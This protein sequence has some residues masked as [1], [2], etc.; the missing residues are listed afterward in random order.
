MI[1]C[2]FYTAGAEKPCSL[3]FY[4]GIPSYKTCLLCI[5]RGDNKKR[6]GLGDV[7]EAIVKPGAK[8]LRLPCLDE[9]SNL[10]PDSGCAKRKRALNKIHL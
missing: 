1:A 10:K 7:V 8:A 6:I 5:G 9:S 4:G 2:K 3:G